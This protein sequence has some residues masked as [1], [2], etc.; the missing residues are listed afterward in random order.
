MAW[1]I[2]TS[3]SA[4]VDLLFS[5][6]GLDEFANYFTLVDEEQNFWNL[7]K[8]PEPEA[9]PVE[10]KKLLHCNTRFLQQ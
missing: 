9:S 5:Y 3:V 4:L 1:A 7:E 2:A 10:L 6:S 8:E